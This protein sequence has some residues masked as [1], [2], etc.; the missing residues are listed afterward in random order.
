MSDLNEKELLEELEWWYKEFNSVYLEVRES[1]NDKSGI[2]RTEQIYAQLRK[3]VEGHFSE[4][5]QVDE[6]QIQLI[7][8]HDEEAG[9][10]YF[11]FTNKPIT[12][13]T[14]EV[15]DLVNIDWDA[16]GKVVGV[17]LLTQKRTVTEKEIR[18][19]I[20]TNWDS[21]QFEWDDTIENIHE[22]L[23]ELGIEVVG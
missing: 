8:S 3:I 23:K 4:P 6:E 1:C 10:Y 22:M 17:E 9:A 13:T 18:G 15:D 2:N 7:K 19:L 11:K 16:Q 21:G 5:V 12:K 14:E 20:V